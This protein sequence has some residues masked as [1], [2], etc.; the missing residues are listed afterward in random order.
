MQMQIQQEP[1]Q[2]QNKIDRNHSAQPQKE[3]QHIDAAIGRAPQ[4]RRAPLVSFLMFASVA[5]YAIKNEQIE[6]IANMKLSLT[7]LWLPARI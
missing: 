5:A 3:Q 7:L 2:Q 6:Q 1:M 4:L